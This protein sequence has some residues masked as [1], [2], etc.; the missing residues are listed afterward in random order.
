MAYVFVVLACLAVLLTRRAMQN[1]ARRDTALW[2]F[3]SGLLVAVTGMLLTFAGPPVVGLVLG[4]L[5]ALLAI[6][7]LW[8]A[9]YL[10][11][12]DAKVR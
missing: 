2:A 12:L 7:D 11:G 3:A 10:W 6:V 8:Y 4:A 1:R 5:C 9:M